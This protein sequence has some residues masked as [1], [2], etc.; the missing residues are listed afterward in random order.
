MAK[1]NLLP[2]REE[3]RKQLTQDYVRRLALSAIL[4]GLVAF[5][6]Y[7]HITSLKNYQNK[8]NGYLNDQIA[9]LTTQLA[10]IAE[11]ESTRERLLARMDVIQTLQTRR[12]QIVHLFFELAATLPD[13]VY[14]TGISQSGN[15][16][17]LAGVTESN[18]RVS[19]YMRNLEASSW[20]KSPRLEVIEADKDNVKS[21][22]KL[23]LVQTTPKEEQEEQQGGKI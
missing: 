17:T 8:R 2:W 20:L 19:A 18:A 21:S 22:F 1:L 5:Y 23:H 16:I 10:E 6:G 9:V 15:N 3:K 13:G 4:T 12:P 7:Y 11:L 14:L